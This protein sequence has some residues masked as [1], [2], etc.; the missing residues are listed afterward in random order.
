M[1]QSKFNFLEDDFSFMSLYLF[2]SLF[3]TA[4]ILYLLEKAV[5]IAKGPFHAK[6]LRYENML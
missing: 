5:D 6:Y 2:L 3:V 4:L 1:T